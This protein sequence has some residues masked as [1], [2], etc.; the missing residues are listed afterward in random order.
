MQTF[1]K[2]ND[3]AAYLELFEKTAIDGRTLITLTKEDLLEI[4][5]PKDKTE[6]IK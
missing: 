4:G 3:L 5:I 6:H 2:Q 1:L